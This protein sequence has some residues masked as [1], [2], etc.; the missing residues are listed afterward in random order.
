MTAPASRAV[1]DDGG[2]LGTVP[3]AGMAMGTP[4]LL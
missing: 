3:G 2:V 4:R 1:A